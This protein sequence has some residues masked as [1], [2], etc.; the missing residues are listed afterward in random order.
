M[1]LI[2]ALFLIGCSAWAAVPLPELDHHL[3]KTGFHNL[4][5]AAVVVG[6][7]DYIRL[8]DVPDADKDAQLVR[9]TMVYTLGIAPDRISLLIRAQD[10]GDA[11]R[12][13]IAQAIQSRAA[14]VPAGG[15]LWVYFAGHGS[16]AAD[17]Q[18]RIL[19]GDDVSAT[20]ASF[21]ERAIR[22]SE[23]QQWGAAY[24]AEVVLVTDACF[25]GMG[26]DGSLQ[27]GTRYAL[28]IS[29]LQKPS[30]TQWHATGPA[31]V[32]QSL[33]N[34][35]HGAFTYFW[36]GALRGW[37]DGQFDSADG[38]VTA[39]EVQEYVSR[40][41]RTVQIEGETPQYTG[42]MDWIISNG[43][44]TAPN[45]EIVQAPVLQAQAP[46][47]PKAP[48]PAPPSAAPTQRH[49]LQSPIL[50]EL[51][52]I[53]GGSYQMGSTLSEVGRDNDEAAHPV[54]VHGFC[55]MEAEVTQG[56]WQRVMADNPSIKSA[57]GQN[58]IGEDYPVQNISWMQAVGYANLVSEVEGLEPFYD[59]QGTEVKQ[60]PLATGYRLPTEA[61]WE[62]A[63]RGGQTRIYSGTSKVEEVCHYGN[64]QDTMGKVIFGWPGSF[65]CSDGYAAL[66]PI[67]HFQPNAFGIY[68][69]MGNVSEWV[70]D[71]YGPYSGSYSASQNPQGRS[72]GLT[73]VYRGG[74]WEVQSEIPR[75]A[76]RYK[77]SPI[78]GYSTVGMRLVRTIDSE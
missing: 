5:D 42:K 28:P 25:N 29:E 34:T 54:E 19:L 47:A 67:K 37:A 57:E 46:V 38:R 78:S 4:Q 14:Q 10:Q 39:A 71:W 55:M 21:A 72:I 45:L 63:A 52:C 16:A 40:S 30:L 62:Y 51:N 26:R 53:A 6:I 12:T 48:P 33:A 11:S 2:P 64:I 36:V 43:K 7:S 65:G 69:M 58:M 17:T 13:A 61:E 22:L 44:E 60:Q 75:L 27:T 24:G 59:I 70:W 9:D 15:K 41:M 49:V 18:E 77:G 74:S 56:M 32:A 73:R 76:D 1:R 68:D 31:Q 23:I 50:G 3:Q 66:A 8:P 20:P 35:G